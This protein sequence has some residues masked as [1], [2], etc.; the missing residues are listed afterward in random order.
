MLDTDADL[1]TLPLPWDPTPAPAPAAHPIPDPFVPY[2][3]E[4][5]SQPPAPQQQR[6]AGPLAHCQASAPVPYQLYQPYQP[7]QS[8]D[9]LDLL[10]APVVPQAELPPPPVAF[11]PPEASAS[12]PAPAAAA[13]GTPQPPHMYAPQALHPPQAQGEQQL[14]HQYHQQQQQQLL[15]QGKWQGP[16]QL[17]A[18]GGMLPPQ[19][20]GSGDAFASPPA[21]SAH[22]WP[23]AC[24]PGQAYLISSPGG[25]Q[26]PQAGMYE[27]QQQQ[28]CYGAPYTAASDPLPYGGYGNAISY[29]GPLSTGSYNTLPGGGAGQGGKLHKAAGAYGTGDGSK[30]KHKNK[31]DSVAAKVIDTVGAVAVGALLCGAKAASAAAQQLD[32]KIA[33]MEQ[34]EARDRAEGKKKKKKGVLRKIVRLIIC[35]AVLA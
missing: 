22:S 15:L 12:A 30:H 3:A 4:P 2:S 33:K 26:N 11:S 24:P 20:G 19:L 14:L 31:K 7:G 29:S 34:K 21:Q 1:P 13:I 32:K 25:G 10:A 9:Q 27:Q 18:Q 5:F 35:A 8:A 6:E 16:M 23:A 17:Q 28:Q